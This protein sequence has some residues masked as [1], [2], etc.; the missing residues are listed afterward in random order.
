M[1]HAAYAIEQNQLQRAV[2]ELQLAAMRGEEAAKL[3]AR[4]RKSKLP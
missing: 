3:L 4:L 2:E 1:H